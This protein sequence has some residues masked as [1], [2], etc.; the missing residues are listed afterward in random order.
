MK[1]QARLRAPAQKTGHTRSVALPTAH[2]VPVGRKPGGDVFL[3]RGL[4]ALTR[5]AEELSEESLRAAAAAPTDYAVLVSALGRPEA[6]TE[7]SRTDPLV[8][9]RLR[10]LAMRQQLLEAEG[11]P[12]RVE[13]V[14][15]LLRLSRQAVDKRR[16]AGRVL[17][18][19]AGRRG[20][21]Y[22]SWQFT[23]HGLLPGLEEVLHDLRLHDPWMQLAFLVSGNLS[24]HSETPLN[25]LRRGQLEA[26]RRA[27][28]LYG[29]QGGA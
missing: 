27:A 4:R 22:P 14:A 20:Y 1:T 17:G 21:A 13:E 12:L 16:R 7:V 26:V 19:R 25:V 24:L 9:A 29:E 18:L 5:L 28:R 2:R 23:A 10:G 6:L 11:G 8:E 15:S 3:R